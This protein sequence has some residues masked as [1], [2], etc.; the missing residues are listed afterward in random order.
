MDEREGKVLEEEETEELAHPNVRPSS[1]HQQEALQVTELTKGIVT[2]HCSLH[3]LLAADSNTN[4][5]S[6]RSRRLTGQNISNTPRLNPR[7]H[8]GTTPHSTTH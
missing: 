7:V 3:P 1:M 6:W 4:V 8:P 5:C 2:G